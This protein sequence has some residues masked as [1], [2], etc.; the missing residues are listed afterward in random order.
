MVKSVFEVEAGD[1]LSIYNR[2]Y[3]VDQVFRLGGGASQ[4]ANYRLKD[5]SEVRWFAVRRSGRELLVLGEEIEPTGEGFAEGSGL[6]GGD[7]A[8][9][10]VTFGEEVF[11][12]IATAQGRSTGTSAMGYPRFINVSYSDYV[13]EESDRYLFVQQSGDERIVFVGETVITSA[14]M[15]FPRPK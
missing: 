9:E 8:G 4:T 7:A 13:G 2:D 3:I 1:I 11:K 14:V 15:V 5:G 12:R 6:T 10:E